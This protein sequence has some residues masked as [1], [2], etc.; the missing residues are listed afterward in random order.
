MTTIGFVGSGNIGSSIARAAI[1]RGDEVV[2]SNSRGPETL[3]DLIAELGE[4]ARAATPAEAAAAGDLVVVTVPFRA[5]DDLPVEPFAGKIVMDTN[6]YYPQRDGVSD[7]IESG[8]I[9][10]SGVL[11]RHL[12]NAHVVKAFN[13]IQALQIISTATPSGTP[14]RRALAIAGDDEHAKRA[15]ADFIDGIGFDVVDVGPLS[16]SWRIDAGTPG[17]GPELTAAELEAALAAAEPHTA[18]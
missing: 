6:N 7:E 12:V 13:H 17:Y 2:L 16:E 4:H 3:A 10:V 11:Q 18:R 5:V 8:A 9:T 15:V 1:A 14:G